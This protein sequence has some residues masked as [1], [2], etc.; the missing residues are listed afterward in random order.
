M[1]Y[2]R[3]V[4]FVFPHVLEGGAPSNAH[5]ITAYITFQKL[6][7]Y[8]CVVMKHTTAA[9]VIINVQRGP[10]F[11]S[12]VSPDS[13]VWST[14]IE[15]FDRR[16]VGRIIG[17]LAKLLDAQGETVSIYTCLQRMLNNY[18]D[19]NE[20]AFMVSEKNTVS[21]TQYNLNKLSRA[22]AGII[23]A[24]DA[25]S[26]IPAKRLPPYPLLNYLSCL[27]S[28]CRSRPSLDTTLSAVIM[29]CTIPMLSTR[30]MLKPP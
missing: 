30:I 24:M 17:F 7:G 29:V 2:L 15:H 28:I 8:L 22:R 10:S 26:S 23:T 9:I 16:G 27:L 20:D 25:R 14:L 6:F 5:V 12:R 3:A 18:Q 11:S 4:N 21:A 19:I 1:N 13:D